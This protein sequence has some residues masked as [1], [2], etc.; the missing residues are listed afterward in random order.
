MAVTNESGQDNLVGAQGLVVPLLVGFEGSPHSTEFRLEGVPGPNGRIGVRAEEL[1][2]VIRRH[3]AGALIYLGVSENDNTGN[4]T[5]T[6]PLEAANGR[7]V[8]D[9]ESSQLRIDDAPTYLPRKQFSILHF[10]MVNREIP[11]SYS[12]IKDRVWRESRSIN[13]TD[14]ALQIQVCRMRRN[15]GDF[16]EIV[17]PWKGF[18]YYFSDKPWTEE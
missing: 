6:E 10:L 1:Q 8:L 12:R 2:D 13:D 17:Q 5:E 4:T 15:L 3:T 11:Q 7:F 16:T 9:P 14:N 18:G